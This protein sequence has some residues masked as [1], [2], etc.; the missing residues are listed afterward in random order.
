MNPTDKIDNLIKLLK[1]PASPELDRRIDALLKHA[2]G[3][4]DRPLNIWSKIMKSNITKS[5]AAA[6]I[7]IGAFFF[8]TQGNGSL[9]LANVIEKFS[10][11]YQCRQTVYYGG[12]EHQVTTLYRL[13]LSQRREEC[14]NNEVFIVD[15]RQTPVRTLYLYENDKFAKG[16]LGSGG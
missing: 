11:P 15:M 2:A 6:M 12:K 9:V 16:C 4:P 7:L 14:P 13:N 10:L 3:Q 1:T 8:L 5:A